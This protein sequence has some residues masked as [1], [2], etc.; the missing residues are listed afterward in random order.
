[1]FLP[2]NM[3]LFFS[4][5]LYSSEEQK[6]ICLLASAVILHDGHFIVIMG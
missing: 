1:M 2:S 5:H 6:G 4:Y 3:M